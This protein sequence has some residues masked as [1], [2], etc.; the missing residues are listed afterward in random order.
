MLGD[1]QKAQLEKFKLFSGW[2][3]NDPKVAS[4]AQFLVALGL[5]NYIET[6]GAFRIG[7]LKKD[8]SG[9][10]L[11][12]SYNKGCGGNHKTTSRERFDNFFAYLG[13]NYE[14]L[15]RNHQEIYD[16]LRRGLTHEFLPKQG[17]S[18]RK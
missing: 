16:G 17:K 6:L 4:D 15:L 10:I 7:Y 8:G 13:S 14:N 1:K 18:N 5:F 12:C 9:Q 11:K 3:Y 2:M